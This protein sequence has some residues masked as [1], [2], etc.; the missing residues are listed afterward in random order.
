M[1]PAEDL[2]SPAWTTPSLTIHLQGNADWR[3]KIL[4]QT[5]QVGIVVAI[6]GLRSGIFEGV[7]VAAIGSYT[8]WWPISR[9]KLVLKADD[10]E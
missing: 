5:G 6:P 1:L 4:E 3:Q 2:F 9:L 7:D 8:Y 10:D